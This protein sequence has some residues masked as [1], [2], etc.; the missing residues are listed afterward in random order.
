MNSEEYPNFNWCDLYTHNSC[1]CMLDLHYKKRN[2]NNYR[3]SEFFTDKRCGIYKR[4]NHK[5]A[6]CYHNKSPKN[7]KQNPMNPK[8][9]TKTTAHVKT[10]LSDVQKSDEF[11]KNFCRHY[12]KFNHTSQECYYKENPKKGKK[13]RPNQPIEVQNPQQKESYDDD[14]EFYD[15]WSSRRAK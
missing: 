2:M 7:Q 13:H 3:T 11:V 12:R 1:E 5:T 9:K 15:K 8:T 10:D 14:L 6:H 4:K